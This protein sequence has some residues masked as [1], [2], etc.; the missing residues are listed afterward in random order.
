MELGINFGYI[1]SDSG[2]RL[3]ETIIDRAKYAKELGF[4]AL[5]FS[6]NIYRDDWRE[7]AYAFRELADRN[8]IHVHQTHLPFNRYNRARSHEEFLPYVSRALEVASILGAKYSVVHAD[9]YRLPKG[10]EYDV[11]R[12]GNFIYDYLAPIV[13]DAKRFGVGIAVEDLFED[14]TYGKPRSRYTSTMD[15]L[16]GIIER[17][18]DEAVSCCW[19]FGHAQ[20]AYGTEGAFEAFKMAFPYITCTHVH[21]NYY[22]KDLHLPPFMGNL[23]WA[24]HM[25]YM[26]ENGYKGNFTYEFVYGKMP[27]EILHEYLIFVKKIADY[28]F[29]L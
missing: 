23:D 29:T 18:N 4:T 8:G 19:D 3:L 22:D 16:L 2:D 5:D 7:R 25:K 26:R 15:E 21:D 11:K 10:E 13:E 28:L 20:V 27:P 6:T 14:F 24:S 1:C 17:F 12:A 9:E